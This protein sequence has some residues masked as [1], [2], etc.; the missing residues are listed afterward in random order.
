M[1]IQKMGL[2]PKRG[3]LPHCLDLTSMI[4]APTATIC[5]THN[6][7]KL[8]MLIKLQKKTSN[9]RYVEKKS[10]FRTE[11]DTE[12]SK[13]NEMITSTLTSRF[14][15]RRLQGCLMEEQVWRL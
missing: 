2:L 8:I 14:V 5:D 3:K 10:Q 13:L 1:N 4:I 11:S 6:P 9:I 12:K 15:W 7:K